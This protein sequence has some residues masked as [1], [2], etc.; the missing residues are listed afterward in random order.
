M[1]IKFRLSA[2]HHTSVMQAVAELSLKRERHY[3][4]WE[5]PGPVSVTQRIAGGSS[6]VATTTI[7]KE[8]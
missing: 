4:D 7:H 3:P 6:Y 8:V 2:A 5:M 1:I